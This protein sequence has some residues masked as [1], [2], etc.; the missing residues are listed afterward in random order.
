[1]RTGFSYNSF[2]LSIFFSERQRIPFAIRSYLYPNYI[3]ENRKNRFQTV[4]HQM[5]KEYVHQKSV[6][7]TIA[8][9]LIFF[10]LSIKKNASLHFCVSHRL[11]PLSIRHK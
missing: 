9:T 1:M 2:E 11:N 8:I 10:A 4:P 5:V 6:R 3:Y 7:V